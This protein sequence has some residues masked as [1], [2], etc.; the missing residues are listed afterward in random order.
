VVSAD[1]VQGH[2]FAL[3]DGYTVTDTDAA[4]FSDDNT[5]ALTIDKTPGSNT[6]RFSSLGEATFTKAGADQASGEYHVL[7]GSTFNLYRYVGTT[8]LT[9][10]NIDTVPLAGT[11]TTVWQP[12][13]QTD[14]TTA[15]TGTPVAY[16]SGSDGVLKSATGSV[17]P[18]LEV[19][20]YYALV[21]TASTVGYTTP[22][23]QWT[24]K[25]IRNNGVVSLD[26]TNILA[27]KG[28][29][30]TLPPAFATSLDIGGTATSGAFVVNTPIFVLPKAGSVPFNAMLLI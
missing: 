27:H 26:T 24:I 22:T 14:G 23:G 16:T 15:T 20:T 6:I 3:G 2:E 30:G 29:D 25:L 19:G 17:L 4:A 10:A 28:T 7:S 9:S 8:A 5:P 12:I 1:H 13:T 21:E 11:D 18:K